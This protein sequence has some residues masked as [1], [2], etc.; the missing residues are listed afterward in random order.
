MKQAEGEIYFT[1][2]QAAEHFNLSL[3]TTRVQIMIEKA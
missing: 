2:K 1:P 3:S